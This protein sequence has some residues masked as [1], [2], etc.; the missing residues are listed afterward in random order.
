M[1]KNKGAVKSSNT[2]LTRGL[3]S[4]CDQL[5]AVWL[6]LVGLLLARGIKPSRLT[7]LGTAEGRGTLSAIA[8]AV[9]EKLAPPVEKTAEASDLA[10][11]Q[12]AKWVGLYRKHFGIELDPAAVKVPAHK[13]GFDRL[14]VVAQGMTPNKVFDVFAKLFPCLRYTDDLDTSVP[15]N[16]RDPKNGT[17][18]VWVRDTI[19]A[20]RETRN[21][22]ADDLTERKIAGVTLL[23]RLLLELAY[24]EETGC[25]LDIESWTLCSGSRYSDG[26]VPGVY[27]DDDRLRVG[28][29]CTDRRGGDLGARVAVS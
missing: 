3:R 14:I 10:S 8:D 13:E 1:A 29:H 22:S 28:W 26:G 20:D 15:K 18:A 24:F 11:A 4:L 9:A 2:G 27:W 16:D 21:L 6:A 12:L 25:H 17:Y 7:W 5:T 19:E 23:E